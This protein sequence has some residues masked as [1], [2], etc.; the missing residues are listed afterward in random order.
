VL[1]LIAKMLQFNDD[2][3]VIIGLKVPPINYLQSFFQSVIGINTEE[4]AIEPPAEV[5]GL[6]PTRILFLVLFTY[7]SH[8]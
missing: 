2:Q 3:L 1:E 8:Y 6:C 7:V 5:S 4:P